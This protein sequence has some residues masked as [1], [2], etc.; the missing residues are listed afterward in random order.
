MAAVHLGQSF[1]LYD[2][3]CCCNI[4]LYRNDAGLDK[5]LAHIGAGYPGT[6]LHT[7]PAACSSDAKKQIYI[8]IEAN[9]S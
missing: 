1:F 4:E 2:M 9:I 5:R 3:R 7:D 6:L 8:G